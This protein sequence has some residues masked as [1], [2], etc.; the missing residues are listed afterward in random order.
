MSSVTSPHTTTFLVQH[1]RHSLHDVMLT[2]IPCIIYITALQSCTP[3]NAQ[4]TVVQLQKIESSPQVKSFYL[5]RM[6]TDHTTEDYTMYWA[7]FDFDGV[8]EPCF[9]FKFSKFAIC[10]IGLCGQQHTCTVITTIRV[11]FKLRP[12]KFVVHSTVVHWGFKNLVH[13]SR[14]SSK[15]LVCTPQETQNQPFQLVCIV[16][17]SCVLHLRVSFQSTS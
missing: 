5:S 14:Y 4:S 6:G 15:A 16:T 2:L 13:L 9:L 10:A 1:H 3:L 17:L 12:F 8:M 7:H 11:Q